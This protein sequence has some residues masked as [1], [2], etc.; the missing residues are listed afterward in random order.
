MRRIQKYKKGYEIFYCCFDDTA[1]T[2]VYNNGLYC[3]V[4]L[5]ERHQLIGYAIF[6]KSDDKKTFYSV[7]TH[8]DP[9]FQRQKVATNLYN[10]AAKEIT[11]VP[12]RHLTKDGLKFWEYRKYKH[13]ISNLIP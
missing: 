9:A 5:S 8:V 10:A 11:I 12:S 3:D 2:D 4:H 13:D 7:D 6:T 1:N